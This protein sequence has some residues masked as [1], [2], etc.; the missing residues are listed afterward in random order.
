MTAASARIV[1]A[2]SAEASST[3]HPTVC[4]VLSMC[5]AATDNSGVYVCYL[6]GLMSVY[7]RRPAKA[8]GFSETHLY[9]VYNQP[10]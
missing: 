4:A 2:V 3:A 10:S 8:V 5:C 1:A 7:F 6:K 9:F